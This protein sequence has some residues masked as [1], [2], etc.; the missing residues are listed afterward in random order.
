MRIWCTLSSTA[1][2]CWETYT[3]REG[4]GQTEVMGL[5]VLYLWNSIEIAHFDNLI[6]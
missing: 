4:H 5:P 6:V 3:I 1:G 2:V